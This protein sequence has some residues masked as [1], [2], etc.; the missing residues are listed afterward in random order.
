MDQAVLMGYCMKYLWIKE[1]VVKEV[2]FLL[3]PRPVPRL[4]QTDSSKSSFE[5]TA[6]VSFDGYSMLP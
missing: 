2:I 4:Q 5:E 3:A 1:N 6:K